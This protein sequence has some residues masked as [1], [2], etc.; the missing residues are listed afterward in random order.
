MKE[1]LLDTMDSRPVSFVGELTSQTKGKVEFADN[2]KSKFHVEAVFD[3]V[4][5]LCAFD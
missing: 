3:R 2:I 1:I 5:W 4:R